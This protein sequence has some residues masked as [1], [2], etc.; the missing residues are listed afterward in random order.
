MKKRSQGRKGG[1]N[2]N[3]AKKKENTQY[4]FGVQVVCHVINVMRSSQKK[5]GKIL[6][7]YEIQL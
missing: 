7:E 2:S 3:D 5:L 6:L 4:D 1:Q